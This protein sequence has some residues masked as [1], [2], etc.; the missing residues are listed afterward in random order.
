MW[1]YCL[2]H[3]LKITASYIPGKENSRADRLSREKPDGSDWKLDP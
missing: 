2:D 1:D 3:G